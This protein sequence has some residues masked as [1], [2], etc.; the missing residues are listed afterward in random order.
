LAGLVGNNLRLAY[1]RTSLGEMDWQERK[2]SG[3][4]AKFFIV[5]DICYYIGSQN[6]YIANLAE[7]GIIIDSEEQTQK[8]LEEYWNP[9]WGKSYRDGDVPEDETPDFHV[10]NVL[11]GLELDRNPEDLGDLSPEEIDAVLLAKKGAK[12]G[13]HTNSLMVW[14]KRADNLKDSDGIGGGSSDA[15]VKLRLVDGDGNTVSVPQESKVIPDGGPNPHWNEQF[16]FEGLDT[17]AAYTLKVSVLDKDSLFGLEGQIA[18]YLAMDDK[19]GAATV[20]LGTL[21]NT[22]EFQDMD[23]TISDGWFSDSTV[24]L[25][26]NTQGEWGN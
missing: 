25:A 26:L 18:D 15:Y 7:W 14:L 19:L 16:V 23:I 3:N 6:L 20:D 1:L 24:T 2:K 17:P 9:L 10:D 22:T 5:D 4:H 21:A 8:V 11:A 12:H 13:G